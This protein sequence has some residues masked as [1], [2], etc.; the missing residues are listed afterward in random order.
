MVYDH[1]EN[2]VCYKLKFIC[3]SALALAPFKLLV[4]EFAKAGVYD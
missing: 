3:P 2:K 1:D 4:D